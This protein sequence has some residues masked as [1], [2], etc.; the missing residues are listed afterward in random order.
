M[1]QTKLHDTICST[2]THSTNSRSNYLKNL[3]KLGF[4]FNKKLLEIDE[5]N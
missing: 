3:T 5:A 1:K 2:T 4:Y